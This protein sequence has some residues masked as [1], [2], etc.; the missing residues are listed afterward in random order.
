MGLS[1]EEIND[2]RAEEKQEERI[3]DLVRLLIT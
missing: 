1:D 2:T 3:Q